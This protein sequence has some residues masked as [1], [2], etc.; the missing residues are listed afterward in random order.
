MAFITSYEH[1]SVYPVILPNAGISSATNPEATVIN[2]MIAK[3]EPEYLQDILGYEL[4]ALFI[5]GVD[6]EDADYLAIKNGATYVDPYGVT[7]KWA[8]FVKGSNPIANYTYC[9]YVANNESKVFNSGV[10][11]GKN[12]NADVVS[13][14]SKIIPA[15]NE[16]VK[17]NFKLHEYL[18]A[19][20][21]KFPKYVGL[22][23]DPHYYNPMN[24]QSNQSLFIAKN[25]FGL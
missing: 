7:Q 12:E 17:F 15:W 9:N 8:G 24:I 16:M 1:F 3:C 2:N 20:Q 6:S 4:Y 19:N 18:V 21:A 10:A 23:Y 13:V 11:K 5:A 22:T 14:D 25:V